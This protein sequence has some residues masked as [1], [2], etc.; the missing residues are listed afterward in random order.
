ME[1]KF[2]KELNIEAMDILDDTPIEDVV[3]YYFKLLVNNNIKKLNN[4]IEQKG[5]KEDI[6]DADFEV[7]NFTA[8][9]KL[10][11]FELENKKLFD[12]EVIE[13]YLTK[14]R[15]KSNEFNNLDVEWGTI[16][17]SEAEIAEAEKEIEDKIKGT[18]AEVK[19]L[20][21]IVKSFVEDLNPNK[22]EPKRDIVL[23]GTVE[24]YDKILSETKRMVFK[25]TKEI[26]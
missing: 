1:D 15:N 12:G 5:K 11:E 9:V 2:L 26:E 6:K 16:I 19:A 8:A 3:D 23:E 13:E 20:K 22:K 7:T 24:S 4:K 18:G 10:Y 21:K 25:E 14:L 17:Q